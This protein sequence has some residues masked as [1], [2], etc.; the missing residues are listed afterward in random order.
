MSTARL[1][2]L[3]EIF[4]CFVSPAART[5]G[6]HV[7]EARTLRV[8]GLVRLF[9]KILEVADECRLRRIRDIV[10]RDDRR[11]VSS[12]SAALPGITFPAGEVVASA[13]RGVDDDRWMPVFMYASLS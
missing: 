2:D 9:V 7:Q 13:N 8:D 1:A 5:W 4:R 6:H 10:G 12:C 3:C 11:Q